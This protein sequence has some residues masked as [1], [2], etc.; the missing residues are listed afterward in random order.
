MDKIKIEIYGY[1]AEVS[2]VSVSKEVWD[3]WRKNDEQDEPEFATLDYIYDVD[4]DVPEKYKFLESDWWGFSD[5]G[6]WGADADYA[7]VSV[8]VNGKEE[9]TVDYNDWFVK[10]IDDG[11]EYKEGHYITLVSEEKGSFFYTEFET[12][13]WDKDKLEVHTMTDDATFIESIVYDGETLDNLGGDTNGKG[14]SVYF[15]GNE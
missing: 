12:E 14:S 2:S 13:K 9:K 10:S 4:I 11:M 5:Y 3:F 7:R 8:E 1:G 15:W 6:V